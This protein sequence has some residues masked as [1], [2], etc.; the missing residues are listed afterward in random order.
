MVASE[1]DYVAAAH[2]RLTG[3][4]SRHI[5]AEPS[6]RT[7]EAPSGNAHWGFA[8]CNSW[9]TVIC[10]L[11]AIFLLAHM[12]GRGSSMPGRGLSCPYPKLGV[13]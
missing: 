1:R 8:I 3:W 11:S 5:G 7:A 4:Q 10:L 6:E 12:S 2:G 13:R 9:F